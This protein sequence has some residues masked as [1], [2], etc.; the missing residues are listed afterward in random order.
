MSSIL[1]D[2]EYPV[3]FNQCLA[4][5]TLANGPYGP[6]GN[7]TFDYRPCKIAESHLDQISG[8][9]ETEEVRD[10]YICQDKKCMKV[11]NGVPPSIAKVFVQHFGAYPLAKYKK[12][13]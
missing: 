8:R 4:M 10:L 7:L 13:I 12:I 11:A 9:S 3:E 6:A 5:Y 2:K 1:P